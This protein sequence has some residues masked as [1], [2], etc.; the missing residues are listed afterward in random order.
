MG[1]RVHILGGGGVLAAALAALFAFLPG[2]GEPEGYDPAAFY[3]PRLDMLVEDLS[4]VDPPKGLFPQGKLDE[5]IARLATKGGRLIAP[6]RTPISLSPMIREALLENFGTPAR[7]AIAHPDAAAFGLD[8]D[9]LAA[10]SRIY[11]QHCV[12][13]HGMVGDGR[14]PTSLWTY[15]HARD[16][17]RARF[18]YVTTPDGLGWPRRDDLH[19]V[20][21]RGIGG[22]SMPPFVLMADE[23]I[24]RVAAYTLHLMFRGLVE[25]DLIAQS[26]D[27]LPPDSMLEAGRRSLKQW[28]GRWRASVERPILPPGLG[29]TE[30]GEADADPV[31]AERVR[32]GHEVY[33]SSRA[34]CATC[35]IDYGR[36]SEWRY[37]IWGV[38]VKAT[39]LTEG[40]YRGGDLPEDI[41]NR[42]RYGIIA[43]GMPAVTHLS[44]GQMTDLVSFLRALPDP[45]HLPPD[46]RKIVYPEVR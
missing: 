9:T 40:R 11:R 6:S 24:D 22:N 44:S 13:C 39:D 32:R 7:P 17:R 3:P 16:F 21:R 34:G 43:S 29:P 38:P 31:H 41:E 25:Y 35:H 36:Q 26:Q 30:P 1:R 10:G 12:Q 15:P 18:K 28:F 20:I 5:S 46:V 37:D 2:C 14:G 4:H 45:M 33:L 19:R 42:I 8:G 27:D 23:D